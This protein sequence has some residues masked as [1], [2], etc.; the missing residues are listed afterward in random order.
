MDQLALSAMLADITAVRQR[1]ELLRQYKGYG[2]NLLQ[3]LGADTDEVKMCRLLYELLSP[4]GSHGQ[5]TKFL[6]LFY[7]EVLGKSFSEAEIAASHVY[8]EY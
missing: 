5:G 3:V 2:F 6:K 4:Q 8:R 1:S 7:Q